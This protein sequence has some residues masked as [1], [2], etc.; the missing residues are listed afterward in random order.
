MSEERTR[1]A[2]GTLTDE[3]RENPVDKYLAKSRRKR[4]FLLLLLLV[5]VV[6]GWLAWRFTSDRP[7]TYADIGEHYKYGSIG[8]EPGVSLAAPAGGVL[9]PYWVFKVLPEICPEKIPG[10]YAGLGLIYEPGRDLPIGVSRR[11]R[12]GFDQVGLNCAS[13][14]TG[15]VRETASSK[16]QIVLGMPSHQFDIEEFFRFILDCSLDERLTA[17][18][19]LGKIEEQGG[20]LNA[21][22]RALYKIALVNQVKL[23]IL[24]LQKRIGIL[25]EDDVTAWGRGRVD[26]FNPYKSIQF[27]W[28]LAKL[29]HEE[30]NGA[31]DFPS[32]WNQK[33]RAQSLPQAQHGMWL[34]WDGNNNSV[35][36]RNLSASLGAGVTPTTIDH[37][38]LQRV[39]DWAWTLAPPPYPYRIDAAE[40]SRGEALY[41]QNCADCHADHRFRQ[42]QAVGSRVGTVVPIA[43]VGTD[44]YRLNSYTETFASNQYSLYPGSKYR[45]THFRK[46]NGYANHPLDGIWARAP[47]LHNGAVPTLRDLLEVPENRPKTFFRGYDVYDQEKVG[48]VSNVPAERGR[49]F[50]LHDTARPGNGNQ[51]HLWGTQLTPDEKDAL[52]EYMKRL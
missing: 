4:F 15:T 5:V 28:P 23:T 24:R 22:D 39:K 1:T 30:L 34:H 46:T 11:W 35:D 10:G 32:L 41:R 31:S 14:H 44:P 45:F 27:N 38:A 43:D 25:L 19:L 48:F 26:T 6:V 7:V 29:P 50:F 37:P 36:E 17:D 16:P 9:P 51:G 12:L 21:L 3:V 47:Y 13:C 42:G 49:R 2:T 33:A 20:D 8:S 18:N 52:V 40:A